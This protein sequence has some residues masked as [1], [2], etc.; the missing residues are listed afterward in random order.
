[1][2]KNRVVWHEGL[3]LRPQHLQQQERYVQHLLE[4]RCKDTRAFNW[5]LT[6]LELD[7]ELLKLGKIAI[8]KAKGI[9]PDG[10]PFDIPNDTPSPIPYDVVK[11]TK[12]TLTY[13]AI[14]LVQPNALLMSNKEDNN[15]LSRNT[16]K[17]IQ[18][19]DL[20]TGQVEGNADI[21]VGELNIRLLTDDDKLN[22]YSIIPIARIVEMDKDKMVHLDETLIPAVMHCNTSN[23]LTSFIKEVQ[24]L[25]KHRGDALA[26]RLAAP[27]STGV[28]EITDFLMLQMMNKYEP[29]LQH[30]Y[31]NKGI[32]PEEFYRILI[33][34]TGELATF[35]KEERRPVD[36]PVYIHDQQQPC[37]EFV[38]NEIRSALSA[39]IE[40]KA[41][42]LEISEHKYGIWVATINDKSLL[43]EAMFVLAVK[44][45]VASEK[46]RSSFPK[47]STIASVERIRDLVNS[48]IPGIELN[49]LAVA[50][51]QIPYHS[52]FTYFEMNTKH[53]F[54][55]QLESAGGM[56]VHVGT[57]LDNLDLE[58][59][60]IRD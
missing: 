49:P 17:D 18:V 51:R 5:G 43:T 45:D 29:L 1:M 44:A 57:K 40:Q 2:N 31:S 20:H 11:E 12:D 38:M 15:P 8:T 25:L 37:F 35:T 13:L 50:P 28:S 59:W 55:K 7:S 42:G 9:F 32:F 58:L 14:P 10:T 27:G 48:H 6:N 4:G 33:M 21:Q 19:S 30:L 3:F 54:W 23:N 47:Q 52:G 39:V 53:E 24:G 41:I 36:L 46:I 16:I 60:A 56:A 26:S 34:L 22:A